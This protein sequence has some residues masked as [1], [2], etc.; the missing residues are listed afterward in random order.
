M[1]DASSTGYVVAGHS[2]V[3]PLPSDPTGPQTRVMLWH[4]AKQGGIPHLIADGDITVNSFDVPASA[5]QPNGAPVVDT[6]DA[7]LTQA[8]GHADPDAANDDTE[9]TD[10]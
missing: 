8:V 2:P 7:R 5:P 3:A 4:V 9:L 1:A 10:L 6:L